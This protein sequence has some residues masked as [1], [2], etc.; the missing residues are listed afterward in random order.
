MLGRAQSLLCLAQ[1]LLC[2]PRS[3]L[4]HPSLALRGP[5][6]A[7]LRSGLALPC[8][9]PALPC[10]GLAL[11]RQDSAFARLGTLA[12]S[13]VL[14][15]DRINIRQSLLVSNLTLCSLSVLEYYMIDQAT[16]EKSIDR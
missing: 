2:L 13:R 12:S 14:L 15:H 16:A 10:Q 9:G 1:A 8:L 3:V 7:L 11:T 6:P 4:L 5:E